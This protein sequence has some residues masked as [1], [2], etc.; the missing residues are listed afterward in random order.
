MHENKKGLLKDV[1]LSPEKE[2]RG[3]CCYCG[4]TL[5]LCIVQCDL[6]LARDY[7]VEAR[8]WNLET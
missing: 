4:C 3:N 1:F 5:T 8:T 7:E 2:Y 6:I